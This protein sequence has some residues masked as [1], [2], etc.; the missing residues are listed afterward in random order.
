LEDSLEPEGQ[1]TFEHDENF[2]PLDSDEFPTAKPRFG[3]DSEE[4]FVM[5]EVFIFHTFC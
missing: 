2:Q 1:E 5:D 4:F 3:N